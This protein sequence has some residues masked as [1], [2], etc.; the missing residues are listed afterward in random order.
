MR[1]SRQI[2][3]VVF[4]GLLKTENNSHF[5][6]RGEGNSVKQQGGECAWMR[7]VE[8]DC[9]NNNNKNTVPLRVV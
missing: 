3:A 1:S 6:G 4:Q 2:Y 9:S 5:G 8:F 7:M